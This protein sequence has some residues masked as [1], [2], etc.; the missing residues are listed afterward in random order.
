[1]SLFILLH[2][3][4]GYADMA[5][6]D[7]GEGDSCHSELKEIRKAARSASELAQ[8]LLTFSRRVES[9]LRPVNLNQELKKVV[10]MLR[11][12]VPK[13]RTSLRSVFRTSLI[14]SRER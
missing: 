11:R 14:R 8:S 10:R 1:M 13:R 9:S 6:L 2:I 3:I 7:L 12:T 4:L 5:L